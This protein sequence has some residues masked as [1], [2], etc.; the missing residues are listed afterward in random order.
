MNESEQSNK[1]EIKEVKEV[2]KDDKLD[3]LLWFKIYCSIVFGI[4][5]GVLN[6][7]GFFIFVL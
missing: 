4:A 2:T 7:T 3:K 5:F 6:F 1:K